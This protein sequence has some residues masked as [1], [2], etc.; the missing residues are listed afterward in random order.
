MSFDAYLILGCAGLH[1]N[2]MVI[3]R[4]TENIVLDLGIIETGDKLMDFLDFTC[5]LFDKTQADWNSIMNILKTLRNTFSL[6]DDKRWDTIQIWV[7]QH[8]KCG[9]FLRLCTKDDFRPTYVEKE[10]LITPKK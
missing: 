3:C 8:K 2:E 6:I 4:G 5:K 7:M 1:V 9:S 10:E